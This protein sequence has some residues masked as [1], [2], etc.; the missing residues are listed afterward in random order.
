MFNK[1]PKVNRILF[2]ITD[3]YTSVKAKQIMLAKRNI[4]IL[5]ISQTLPY[6]SPLTAFVLHVLISKNIIYAVCN[7]NRDE[8][9]DL[10]NMMDSNQKLF[11]FCQ[12]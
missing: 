6:S 3:I 4:N 8:T 11:L 1:I 9:D 10:A 12:S 5:I 2:E 7:D